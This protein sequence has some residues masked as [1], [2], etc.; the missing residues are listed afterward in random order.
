VNG[1]V[2]TA[3][4]AR[5][6]NADSFRELLAS[7]YGI[8]IRGNRADCPNCEG[9]SQLTMAV[10]SDY[11]YC[12][13]CHRTIQHR[14]LARAVGVAIPRETPEQRAERARAR[15]FEEWKDT[16]WRILS[17]ELVRSTV[18]AQFAKRTLE[19]FPKDEVAWRELAEFYHA[20]PILMA[21]LDYLSCEKVSV[22]LERPT[23][24]EELRAA[25]DEAVARV[26]ERR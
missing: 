16:L 19:I 4:P 23:T 24:K 2:Y 3:D 26:G 15:E 11:A 20:E 25:F 5:E 10:R 1:N 6:S 21:S 8:Q 9:T 22:W 17:G 12:H 18:I 13:R 7:K 14:E